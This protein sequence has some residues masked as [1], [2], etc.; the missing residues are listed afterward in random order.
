MRAIF[1]FQDVTKIVQG[2][3]EL[4]T[5]LN[6]AQMAAYHDAKQERW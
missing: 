1:C 5:N 2:L 3:Q 4:G 6:E